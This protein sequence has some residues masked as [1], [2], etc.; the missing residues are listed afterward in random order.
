V[1]NIGYCVINELNADHLDESIR[2]FLRHHPYVQHFVP[3]GR[4]TE[5]GRR[6]YAAKRELEARKAQRAGIR[7][8]RPLPDDE[9]RST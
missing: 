6:L 5:Q 4:V 9:P 1:A 7:L 8:E 3:V 2:F